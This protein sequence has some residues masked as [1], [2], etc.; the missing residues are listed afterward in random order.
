ML[1]VAKIKNIIIEKTYVK[2]MGAYIYVNESFIPVVYFVDY[3]AYAN[4]VKSEVNDS[5]ENK[6][7]FLLI[8]VLFSSLSNIHRQKDLID[9]I[10]RFTRDSP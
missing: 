4:L 5:P 1:C 8:S 3:H 9:L 7:I 2:Y 10:Y 6:R